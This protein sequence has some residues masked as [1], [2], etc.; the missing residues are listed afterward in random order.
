MYPLTPIIHNNIKKSLAD[1]KKM[2]ELLSA[3]GSPL[4]FVCQE[5]EPR[6]LGSFYFFSFKAELF[7]CFSVK[8]IISIILCIFF[9]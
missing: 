1:N 7:C 9:C 4:N 6:C 2:E 5:K 8:M 3:F